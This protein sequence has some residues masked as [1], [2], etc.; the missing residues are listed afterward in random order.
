M[1]THYSDDML[2]IAFR[3]DHEDILNPAAHDLDDFDEAIFNRFD[4]QLTKQADAAGIASDPATRSS[5]LLQAQF[6]TQLTP[7][8]KVEDAIEYFLNVF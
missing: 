8:P 4:K 7:K 1:A 5:V 6:S 2:R 3:I